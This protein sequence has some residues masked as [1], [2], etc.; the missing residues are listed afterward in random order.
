LTQ[1]EAA[2]KA[3][4]ADT[5]AR[6]KAYEII[7][8]PLVRSA[9][10]DAFLKVGGS[11]EALMRP[12]AEGVK[13]RT[14]HLL[15]E[16][17]TKTKDGGLEIRKRHRMIPD[18]PTRLKAS[19]LGMAVFGGLPKQLESP[20]VPSQ[21]L[22][23]IFEDEQPDGAKR[24]MAAKIEQSGEPVTV[25]FDDEPDQGRAHLG[26]HRAAISGGSARQDGGRQKK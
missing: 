25:R 1:Y 23:V 24:R 4:Y 16:I 2:R 5:T 14:P 22:T 15:G 21:G 13:A 12:I 7:Q 20:P 3:G 19:E 10:T 6:K 18:A 17:R 26:V 11:M 9:L 8:R